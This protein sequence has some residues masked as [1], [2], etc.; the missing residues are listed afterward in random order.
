ME[1]DSMKNLELDKICRICLAVK[2][3]M[4]PLFGE[5]VAEM[6]MEIARIHIEQMDGWPDKICIQCIHQ[7]SRCHAFK[8]RVEKS[9]ST[10]RQYI[11]GITVVVEE[12]MP[13]EIALEAQRQAISPQKIQQIQP[14][15]EIHIQRTD[16]P[17]LAEAPTPTMILTNAQLL[18]TGTQIINA[19]HLLTTASG[20]QI[21][22]APQYH[23]AQIGQFIQNP[24]NT[25]QMITHGGAH[26]AQILQ[27]QRTA[28]DRCEII[29]QPEMTEQQYYEENNV[30]SVNPVQSVPVMMA[31]PTTTL[32]Q[33]HQITHQAIQ[34]H[35]HHQQQ[36]QQHL[37]E[38]ELQEDELEECQVKDSLDFDSGEPDDSQNEIEE[39][40]DEEQQDEEEVEMESDDKF[41]ITDCESDDDEK[42]LAEFMTYQTSC[43]SPGRYVCNL[44]RKEFSQPKWLQ[45][46]MSSHSN[47]LKANCKKQPECEVC[48]KSFRGPGMLRMHMKTHERADRLPTCSIC[49][50]EFKSKSILYRHRQ[51]HFE[52]NFACT[53]CDKRFSSNYQLNIHMQ[54]HK[55]QKPHKCP[56]CEKSFY[57]ASDLKVHVNQHLGIK[58]IQIKKVSATS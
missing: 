44:C 47:W 27:I 20:Q 51:T 34:Q 39:I 46:H 45:T 29:L 4:R 8:T 28:D 42:K 5:M 40:I 54:R 43:P 38:E 55:K 48:H 21:I 56:H 23:A 33:H 36:Q 58:V 26:P 1:L 3:E 37:Q 32:Q 15:Q 12:D 14:I 9:D 57:N 25:I 19:G 10:L 17:T 22:Q 49:Q 18:N 52:K 31:A 50:K 6:L 24:N 7:V 53:L 2:K 41:Y 35:Q 13:K 16:I 11:K 30:I